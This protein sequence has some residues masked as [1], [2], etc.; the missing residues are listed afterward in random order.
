MANNIVHVPLR[1]DYDASEDLH[2]IIN[3]PKTHLTL[4]QYRN[5][6]VPVSAPLPPIQ[7]MGYLLRNFYHTAY[8]NYASTLPSARLGSLSQLSL[9]SD[10]WFI[11]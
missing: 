2:Q 6:R 1:F 11:L 4:G 8:R 7:F 9:K 10:G 5:C 3:H